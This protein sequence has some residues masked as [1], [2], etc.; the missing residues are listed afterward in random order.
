MFAKAGMCM[1]YCN[2]PTKS[3]MKLSS[4]TGMLSS[5]TRYG[6]VNLFPSLE[7]LIFVSSILR[8]SLEYKLA[9]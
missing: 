1:V 9:S 4:A 3:T 7:I 5:G 2:A 6:G 8:P